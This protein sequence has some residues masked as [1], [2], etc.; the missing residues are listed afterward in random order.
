MKNPLFRQAGPG[1]FL[2]VRRQTPS[3]GRLPGLARRAGEH[4]LLAALRAT[5]SPARGLCERTH[6]LALSACDIVKLLKRVKAW[7]M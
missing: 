5:Y 7:L 4:G 3:R 2:V 6:T 1:G